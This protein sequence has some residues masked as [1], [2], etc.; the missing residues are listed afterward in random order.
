[1]RREESRKFAIEYS[2]ICKSMYKSLEQKN[3]LFA[4]LY[5][6][7]KKTFL[8][9]Y[10]KTANMSNYILQIIIKN[11]ENCKFIRKSNFLEE[12]INTPKFQAGDI[13]VLTNLDTDWCF[14]ELTFL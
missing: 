9:I 2:G 14:S 12:S 11:K 1:M 6:V 4:K 5:S 7:Y 13:S 10:S 3:N 8:D